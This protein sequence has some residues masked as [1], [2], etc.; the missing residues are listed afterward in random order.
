MSPDPRAGSHAGSHVN[1]TTPT[2][3]RLEDDI[4]RQRDELAS[5]V[6]ALQARLDVKAR[7]KHKADELRDRA[8]DDRGRPRPQVV[9]A[10]VAVLAVVGALVALRVR[11]HH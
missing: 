7:T 4:A 10:G 3:D 9:A 6:D 1:G 11:R 8:T 2:A 5:T